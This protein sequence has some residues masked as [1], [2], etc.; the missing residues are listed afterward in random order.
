MTTM[1][2]KAAI[3]RTLSLESLGSALLAKHVD[4]EKRKFMGGS[5]NKGRRMDSKSHSMK[6]HPRGPMP[7]YEGP[8]HV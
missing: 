1:D 5:E 7:K 2:N 6:S 3:P 4:R 8:R